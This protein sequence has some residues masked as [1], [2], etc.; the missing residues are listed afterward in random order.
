MKVQ[1]L[2]NVASSSMAEN[3]SVR[4]QFELVSAILNEAGMPQAAMGN[5]RVVSSVEGVGT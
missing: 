5:F 3:I 1:D 2:S 4:H